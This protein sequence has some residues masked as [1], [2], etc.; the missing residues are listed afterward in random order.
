MM[1]SFWAGFLAATALWL[2][3]AVLWALWNIIVE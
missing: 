1:D 3:V 2:C